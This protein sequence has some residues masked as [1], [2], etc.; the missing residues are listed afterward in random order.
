MNV[1][2]MKYESLD[3]FISCDASTVNAM[4]SSESSNADEMMSVGIWYVY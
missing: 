4:T 3:Y 1:A 2:V